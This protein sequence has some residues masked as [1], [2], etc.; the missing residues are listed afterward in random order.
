MGTGPR[1]SQPASSRPASTDVRPREKTLLE[2]I[3]DESRELVT[4][5]RGREYSAVSAELA[6]L[7]YAQPDLKNVDHRELLHAINEALGTGGLIGQDVYILPF[8]NT[9]ANT[10]SAV[11]ILG[12]RFKAKLCV[13]GGGARGFLM[14]NRYANEPFKL[15]AGTNPGIYHE[16]MDPATR[17]E[18]LGA[19]GV[20]FINQWLQIPVYL[21]V[22]EIEEVRA[23]SRAWSPAVLQR[24]GASAD[25]PYWYGPKTC[26]NR[27][28]KLL[29]NNPR[30]SR[31]LGFTKAEEDY[32]FGDAL[33]ADSPQRQRHTVEDLGLV[34]RSDA[35]APVVQSHP[36]PT[37]AAENGPA[38]VTDDQRRAA[39]SYKLPGSEKS[40]GGHAGVA[41]GEAPLSVLNAA[42]KWA[43]QQKAAPDG[44]RL[45]A[46]LE[47][48]TM[49]AIL[50]REAVEGQG[51]IFPQAVET[52]G[53][54]N[55]VREG[56]R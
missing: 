1:S 26:I 5:P 54:P 2:Q 35:V 11:V 16:P 47:R 45:A 3:V 49:L 33:E 37:P 27:L 43:R 53:A 38:A 22:A 14:H 48:M 36:A 42:H 50:D 44:Y 51:D 28:V 9:R 13:L 19:Y 34:Q 24:M 39:L 7:E 23:K 30:L 29:P 52:A 41:L 21:S 15:T 18:Q 25:L 55:A 56:G 17:G 20:A 4:L 32:E 12:Y 31:I 8:K 40:W 46:E 6:Q 10:Y